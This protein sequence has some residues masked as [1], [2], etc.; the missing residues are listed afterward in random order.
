MKTPLGSLLLGIYF[1]VAYV[2]PLFRFT[3]PLHAYV[4]Y[5]LGI[6]AAL[7]LLRAEAHPRANNYG[8]MV[9]ALWLLVHSTL[10]VLNALFGWYI[11]FWFDLQQWVL[12]AAGILLLTTEGAMQRQLWGFRL[13]AVWCIV[14]GFVPMLMAA[15]TELATTVSTLMAV[16]GVAVG[17]LLIIRR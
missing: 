13:L 5:G 14:S 11:G 4:L 12:L 2:P 15:S 16:L 3:L 10:N 6:A 1:L 9:L 17:V 7:V 8:L